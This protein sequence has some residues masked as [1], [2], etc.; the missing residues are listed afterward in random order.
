LFRGIRWTDLRRLNLDASS[1]ITIYRKLNGTVYKL[2]PNSV[3]Y[4]LPIAD[5]VIRLSNIP[6]NIRQ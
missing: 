1:A 6:Q 4:I 3:N 5:D 2:E